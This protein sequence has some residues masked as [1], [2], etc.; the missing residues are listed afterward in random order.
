MATKHDGKCHFG[1]ELKKKKIVLTHFGGM[2]QKFKARYNAIFAWKKD[3]MLCTKD[4]KGVWN[5]YEANDTMV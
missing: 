2:K 3:A 4:D 1:S 5:K